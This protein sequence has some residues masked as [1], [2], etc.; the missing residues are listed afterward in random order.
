MACRRMVGASLGALLLGCMMAPAG[1]AGRSKGTILVSDRAGDAYVLSRGDHWSSTNASLEA[2]RAVQRRFSGEF[3]WVRRAG[4]EYL[5]RDRRTIDEA[6]SLFAPLRQLDPERAAL[7]R[8]QSRLEADEA[9]LDRKQEKL[10]RELD[11][12]SDDSELRDEEPVRR[13]LESRQRE[14]ESR[15]RALE[16]RER[17]LEAVERSIDRREDDLEE[18]AE[19]ELWRLIDGALDGGLAQ[20]LGAP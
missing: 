2:C 11:R 15:M 13:R 1:A 16:D 8:R 7:E 6:Q 3:L 17:E 14:L 12:L 20:S 5:I 18:K 9:A 10:E 19:R 4:K